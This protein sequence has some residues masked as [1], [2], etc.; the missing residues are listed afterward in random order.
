MAWP[1]S[2]VPPGS[3]LA[4]QQYL[5]L[6]SQTGKTKAHDPFS[7]SPLSRKQDVLFVALSLKTWTYDPE[8]VAEV[9]LAILDTRGIQHLAPGTS[10]RGWFGEI[11]RLRLV[12]K[13]LA[14]LAKQDSGGVRLPG[15]EPRETKMLSRE[16]M[17]ALVRSVLRYGLHSERREKRKVLLVV[18]D[19]ECQER[20]LW[21]LD[22]GAF[23]KTDVVFTADTQ[24]YASEAGRGVSLAR[25]MKTFHVKNGGRGSHGNDAVYV[26]QVLLGMVCL[27]TF[28]KKKFYQG[29]AR[30]V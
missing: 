25:V 9:S 8:R 17:K 23:K 26:L 6:S 28:E 27:R 22:E 13:D 21:Y 5:G 3:M 15:T 29:R 12:D 19:Q 14:E 10:G 16:D 30:L 11:E 4:L 18:H 2:Y 7:P 24:V 1:S 20:L